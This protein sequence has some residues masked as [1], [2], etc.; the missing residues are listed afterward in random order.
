MALRHVGAFLLTFFFG[1]ALAFAVETGKADGN[2]TINRKPV[3][4]KYAFAM[5]EKDPFEKKDRW[6]VMLTDRPLSRSL[7]SDSSRFSKAVENGDVVA[8]I[9]RFD[10]KNDS[11]HQTEKVK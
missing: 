4:L 6:T 7:L 1:S 3:K 9:F 2:V 10:D 11:I 5:K 8:V